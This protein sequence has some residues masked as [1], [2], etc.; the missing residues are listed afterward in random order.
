MSARWA[1]AGN[2]LFALLFAAAFAAYI[3]YCRSQVEEAERKRAIAAEKSRIAAEQYRAKRDQQCATV[4]EALAV[5]A[6]RG[7]TDLAQGGK[8]LPACQRIESE[9]CGYKV[10]L[11]YELRSAARTDFVQALSKIGEDCERGLEFAIKHGLA[12]FRDHHKILVEALE[13]EHDGRELDDYSPPPD[14]DVA[15]FGR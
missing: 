11:L 8:N 5:V 15:R 7:R 6:G 2:W 10:E 12:A 13:E 9:G 4:N 1:R 14:D 3:P